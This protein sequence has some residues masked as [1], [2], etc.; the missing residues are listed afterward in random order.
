MVSISDGAIVGKL[1]PRAIGLVLEWWSLHQA[2]LA[3]N[4]QLLSQGREPQ[5]IEPLE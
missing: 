3:E 4:W 2:E 5:K 1:P